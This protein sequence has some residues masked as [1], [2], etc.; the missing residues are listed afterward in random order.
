MNARHTRH[1]DTYE[2]PARLEWWANP[3]T[4]LGSVNVSV[5]VVSDDSGWR[6]S[7]AFASPMSSED[8]AG[9]EFLMALAPYFSLRFEGDED[10]AID[11]RMDEPDEGELTLTA[12]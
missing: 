8:R 7:A 11:V 9:W 2:G 6:V 5:L 4:C 3:D 12:A 10:A 1:M